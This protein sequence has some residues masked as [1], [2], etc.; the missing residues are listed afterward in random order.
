MSGTQIASS[1]ST[2]NKASWAILSA[3]GLTLVLYIVPFLQ[4]I[5]YPF[6]LLSTLVHEMGHGLAAVLCGGHFVSLQ[7]WGDGSGIAQIHGDFGHFSRAMVAASGLVG[8]AIAA[9]LCFTFINSERRARLLLG[10]MA[11]I[12]AL[13]ILLL[14]RNLFGLFFVAA[15]CATCLFFSLGRGHKYAQAA[16]AFIATQLALSVFSRSDYLFTKEA[17]T[18]GGLMPSDV[19]QIASALFLPYW[20]WGALCGLFS[21]AVLAFGIKRIFR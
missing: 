19:Q 2:L 15:L 14:I 9:S 20:F 1:H 18:S 11:I 13:S 12:L 5:A 8:P 10:T 16:L 7:M 3:T 21:L 6:M 4:P 17:K